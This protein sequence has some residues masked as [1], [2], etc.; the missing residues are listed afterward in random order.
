[1]RAVMLRDFTSLIRAKVDA[2]GDAGAFGAI[3]PTC[4]PNNIPSHVRFK[5]STTM[6][7]SCDLFFEGPRKRHPC[8]L[9]FDYDL[10]L[11]IYAP[12]DRSG[13]VC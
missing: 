11:G 13:G 3:S 2:H 6:S 9:V 1:M 7:R 10:N 12:C 5:E 4:I 8:A